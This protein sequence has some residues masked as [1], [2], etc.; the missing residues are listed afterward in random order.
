MTTNGTLHNIHYRRSG[1]MHGVRAVPDTSSNTDVL[2]AR[3]SDDTANNNGF[4]IA[5]YWE[6]NSNEYDWS[7]WDQVHDDVPVANSIARFIVSSDSA[8]IC[9][10]LEDSDG[11][12]NAGV[13]GTDN[14]NQ[15]DV[16]TD[17]YLQQALDFCA[18]GDGL[19]KL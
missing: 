17:T 16:Y 12:I 1:G 11:A 4:I 18:A 8:L 5:Y 2:R 9:A 10:D 13:M 15:G 3:Q 6:D 14:D 7:N 19:K